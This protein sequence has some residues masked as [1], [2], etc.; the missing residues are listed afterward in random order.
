MKENCNFTLLF[1]VIMTYIVCPA[2]YAV[3]AVYTYPGDVIEN[4]MLFMAAW[5]IVA[6]YDGKFKTAVMWLMRYIVMFLPLWIVYYVIYM[7]TESGYV[8]LWGLARIV[9]ANSLT[10]LGAFW[11]KKLFDETAVV[12]V[13]LAVCYILI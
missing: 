11:A 6:Y 5:W 4:V 13:L 1:P 7:N 10:G 2:A 8:P 3:T 12:F 9:I